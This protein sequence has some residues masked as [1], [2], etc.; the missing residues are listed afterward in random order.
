MV[1][2]HVTG[3]RVA[4]GIAPLIYADGRLAASQSLTAGHVPGG[5]NLSAITQFLPKDLK[6]FRVKIR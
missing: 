2:G 4:E 3:V 6:S 1:I 5:S